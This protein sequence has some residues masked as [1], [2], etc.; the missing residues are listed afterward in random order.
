MA[1]AFKVCEIG[2]TRYLLLQGP[3]EPDIT[4]VM[5][6]FGIRHLRLNRPTERQV[7][8]NFLRELPFVERLELSALSV[9]DVS[10]L[11]DMPN[12]RRLTVTGFKQKVDFTR[13]PKLEELRLDWHEKSFSSLLKCG[14]LRILGLGYYTHIDLQQLKNL[15]FL[16][17][18]VIGFSRIENLAGVEHLPELGKLSADYVKNLETLE[19]VAACRKLRSLSIDEAKGLRRIDPVSSLRD[20]QELCLKRCPEIESLTPI[21]GLPALEYV[22]LLETTNIKDGDLSVL[23]TLPRLKHASFVDRRHYNHKN[24]EFPKTYRAP[25]KLVVL[26]DSSS[27]AQTSSS[28]R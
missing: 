3:W 17:E 16:Q 11:Y 19:P 5:T 4:D 7:E 13:I 24:A 27:S 9:A 20:L 10:P 22:G 14:Q 15:R 12:L 28:I 1:S 18:L 6:T 26:Y 23:L 21:K 25:N 2:P 8:I